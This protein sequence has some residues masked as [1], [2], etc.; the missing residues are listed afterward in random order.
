MG[1]TRTRT[2]PLG[3]FKRIERNL[4]RK[5]KEYSRLDDLSVM[6]RV[7][8]YRPS[9]LAA[10]VLSVNRVRKAKRAFENIYGFTELA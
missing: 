5:K 8:R 1:N 2:R 3:S 6:R 4:P 7:S 10:T 9:N